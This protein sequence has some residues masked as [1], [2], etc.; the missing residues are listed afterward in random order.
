VIPRRAA[1][2]VRCAS[3][4]AAQPGVLVCLLPAREF[5]R[6]R[7]NFGS[8]VRDHMPSETTRS[9]LYATL[10]AHTRATPTGSCST[11]WRPGTPSL[12]TEGCS[13]RASLPSISASYSSSGCPRRHTAALV[14][15][16]GDRRRGG[17]LP[18]L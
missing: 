12:R 14:V 4:R 3:E 6:Q 18:S 10:P 8:G 17:G 2:P 5:T 11:R 13:R 1:T 9:A 7:D 16:S 15:R